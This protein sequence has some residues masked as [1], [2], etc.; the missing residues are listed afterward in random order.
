MS[1]AEFN[2]QIHPEKL[3]N[4]QETLLD[5][6][7][8]ISIYARTRRR[9]GVPGNYRIIEEKRD[10]FPIDFAREEGEF[11]LKDH[12]EHPDAPLSPV[13][14]N[15]RNLPEDLIKEIGRNLAK[16]RLYTTVNM[17]TGIPEAGTELAKAFSEFSGI[18]FVPIFTKEE[19]EKRKRIVI[20]SDVNQYEGKLLLID[21]TLSEG[22]ASR[23]VIEAIKNL[24]G[25]QLREFL[26]VANREQGGAEMLRNMG[27]SVNF[28]YSFPSQILPYGLRSGQIN[29][30]KYDEI[31]KYFASFRK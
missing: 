10:T 13:L 27:N 9:I 11:A 16:V 23:E 24:H 29:Q 30:T 5:H 2:Q 6:L 21:D 31:K 1:R 4:E 20:S 28:I 26:F 17:C 7:F 18:P 19:I 3:T 14:I 25:L 12:L 15:L 22:H 8:T